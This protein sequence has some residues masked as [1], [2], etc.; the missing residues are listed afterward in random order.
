[1]NIIAPGAVYSTMTDEIL[2]AGEEKAGRKEIE[3][4]LL[5]S[6]IDLAVHSLKDVPAILPEGLEQP[7]H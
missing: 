3:D 5:R 6:D 7:P 4:A 2:R 1:M